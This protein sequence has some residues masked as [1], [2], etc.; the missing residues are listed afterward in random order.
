MCFFSVP[1][2]FAGVFGGV[3]L[4]Y[5]CSWLYDKGCDLLRN[6]AMQQQLRQEEQQEQPNQPCSPPA[7][8][9]DPTG[10]KTVNDPT[11]PDFEI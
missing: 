6:R 7:N 5:V 3:V 11:V 2:I 10:N 4:L 1:L 9:P 8:Q